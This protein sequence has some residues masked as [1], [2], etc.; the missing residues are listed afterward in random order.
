ML[1][2][3]MNNHKMVRIGTTAPQRTLFWN[4]DRTCA[5]LLSKGIEPTI[6]LVAKALKVKESEVEQVKGRLNRDVS[7][8]A[9]AYRD[10]D[11]VNKPTIGDMIPSNTPDPEELYIN[12]ERDDHLRT[13][14]TDFG[15]TLSGTAKVVFEQR[16][17][18]DSPK[19]LQVIADSLGVSKQRI[20]QL[21]LRLRERLKEE[22]FDALNDRR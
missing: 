14:F 21:E 7:T 19:E 8:D 4:Y 3:I 18:T 9:P 13:L 15:N 6:A 22:H 12:N 17:Y 5:E 10:L 11:D 20:H 2:Y 16:M 1:K